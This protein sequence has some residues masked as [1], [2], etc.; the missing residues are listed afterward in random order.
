MNRTQYLGDPQPV[1]VRR[2]RAGQE[3]AAQRALDR[4]VLIDQ[5]L[6]PLTNRAMSRQVRRRN[7]REAN[8]AI[9]RTVA[10]NQHLA[11][12]KEMRS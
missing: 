10:R 8:K 7:L 11:F 3:R 9:A 1:Y 12:L 4:S 5:L 2:P 6:G